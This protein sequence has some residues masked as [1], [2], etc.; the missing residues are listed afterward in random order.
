MVQWNLYFGTPLHRRYLSLERTDFDPNRK[1]LAWRFSLLPSV[2]EKPLLEGQKIWSTLRQ[3]LLQHLRLVSLLK[4]YV[5]WRNILLFPRESL[6]YSLHC[7]T[8]AEILF[9][10]WSHASITSDRRK[11]GICEFLNLIIFWLTLLITLYLNGNTVYRFSKSARTFIHKNLSVALI[12]AQLLFLFGINK[13][14]NEVS[15]S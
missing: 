5:F 11:K 9:R 13:T 4:G 8:F 10:S 6:E 2:E 3:M 15:P 7:G 14:K 12:L 1:V